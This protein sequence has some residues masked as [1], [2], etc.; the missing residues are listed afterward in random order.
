[1]RM[2]DLIMKKR[3]GDA[4]TDSEIEYM[5]SDY[6][7]GGI[8]DY[9]MSAM[10]MAIYFKG[11]SDHETA[12]MTNAVAH[13]GDMVDLSGINGIKVDKHSTGGVGDK[14]TLVIGPIVAACGVKVAK[15]SGRGLG[16]TGGTVDKM[17]AIPGMRTSLDTEEFFDV[18]NKTGLSVVGQS[19]NLAPADKKLY[20]LRDVT[21]T[22]DSIP[23][24]AASIM[25]K[26]LAAGNDCILL[27]VKTGSGAFMKSLDDSI[28][29]AQKMV[30]I[31]EHAGKR[32]VALITDM[33]IPLGYGIG[34]SLEVIE[35]VETLQGKGPQD[36]T[37]VC[38]SLASNMLY[39]AN[40]GTVEE[41]R[42][43]AVNA[44]ESG[45]AL[46]KLIAM[47]EAQGGDTQ[48]IKDTEKFKKAAYV[49]DVVAKS[50]GYITHINTEQCGIASVA[51]GAG[52]ETKDSIIDYAAGIV[53]KKKYGDQVEAGDVLATL[54]AE[55]ESYFATA[56]ELI[57]RAYKIGTDKPENKPLV[58]A[59]VDK[60]SVEKY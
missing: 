40:K 56:S 35:A 3:N 26:K 34:N 24:I 30:A 13:S 45:E 15:M 18:V 53:L 42:K 51:L 50:K 22:V 7:A 58:Y 1:M 8:P 16:H 29:L 6:V 28:L 31:G 55:K 59:R 46:N 43:M 20:A 38:I 25:S 39:L 47:V 12:V 36:L 9:Q 48:V 27:D 33:D 57:E 52:R 4:L 44:I 37:E 32:T 49:Y 60:N 19:G 41:C 21:A 14:T 23:L 10:L 17:E 11:M 2:Y 54:Y 5:I